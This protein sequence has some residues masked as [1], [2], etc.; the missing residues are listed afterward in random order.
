[1]VGPTRISIHSINAIVLFFNHTLS[2]FPHEPWKE[3]VGEWS[4]SKAKLPSLTITK[5]QLDK[6]Y[7]PQPS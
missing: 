5:F 7:A 4:E 6:Q 2:Y 1:M 3:Q